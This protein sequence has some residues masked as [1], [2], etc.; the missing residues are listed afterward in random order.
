MKTIGIVGL[1]LIGGSFARAYKVSGPEFTVYAAEKDAS[2]LAFARL[3]GAVD[4]ELTRERLAECDCVLVCLHTA[5]SVAWLEENAPYIP[6]SCMVIDCCGIKRRIC[7]TGFRLARQRGFEYAGGHPMAG[8]HRWGFKNSSARMFEGASF[9]AVPRVFDDVTLLARIKSF[10]MPAG[11]A[12]FVVTTAERHDRLIAFTSQLAHV[13]SN[14][15]I[16]SPTAREHLGFSA[17]SYHDMTRVAW[18]NPT[19]WTDLFIENSDYLTAEVDG[20][21]RELRKY[22]DAISRRDE[23]TLWALLEEGRVRKEEVDG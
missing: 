17:G 18:L 21:I 6:A 4:G 7:E 10:V 16:K 14:A 20:I 13:V 3:A 22:R 9:V 19:M 23:K 8:T 2:V 11:F 1:G 12:H 5:L 15:Y